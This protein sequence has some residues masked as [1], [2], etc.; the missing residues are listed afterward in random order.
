M[1]FAPRTVQCMPVVF[2]PLAIL[3]PASTTLDRTSFSFFTTS[4]QMGYALGANP[5]YLYWKRVSGD[6]PSGRAREPQP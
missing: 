5:S 1:A 2:E 4:C 3:Q 6:S